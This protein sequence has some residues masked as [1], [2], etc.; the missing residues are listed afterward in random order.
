MCAQCIQCA[1]SAGIEG[2]HKGHPYNVDGRD[3]VGIGRHRLIAGAAAMV[4]RWIS[5]RSWRA[6][7]PIRPY[8]MVTLDFDVFDAGG[9]TDPPLRH[10]ATL[11]FGAFVAGA[12]VRIQD[13]GQSGTYRLKQTNN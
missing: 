4:Q 6:D 5:M 2:A 11:D 12:I 7:T 1:P 8:T 13:N 9:Y 3:D 10:G